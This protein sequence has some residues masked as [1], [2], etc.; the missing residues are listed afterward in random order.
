MP[1]A[2]GWWGEAEENRRPEGAGGWL[3]R[4]GSGRKLLPSADS[5]PPKIWA[6]KMLT[7]HPL[8]TKPHTRN[9]HRHCLI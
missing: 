2:K 4:K 8:C 6:G 5:D 3:V 7:E 9:F 1:L